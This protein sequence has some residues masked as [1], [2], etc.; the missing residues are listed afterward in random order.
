[1]VTQAGK[2]TEIPAGVD[3]RSVRRSFQYTNALNSARCRLLFFFFFLDQRI[4]VLRVHYLLRRTD[5]VKLVNLW[6]PFSPYFMEP[7][8]HTHFVFG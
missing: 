4:N 8:P 6:P 7:F 3:R 5:R 1:M 2:L